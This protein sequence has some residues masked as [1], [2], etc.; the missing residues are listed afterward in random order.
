MINAALIVVY[1]RCLLSFH[2]KLKSHSAFSSIVFAPF[3][4]N[5]LKIRT[6]IVFILYPD[7]SFSTTNRSTSYMISPF[8]TCRMHE[9][10][11]AISMF[12]CH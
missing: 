12:S 10:I 11:S 3:S 1:K 2:A 6:L 7:S 4:I 8:S 5:H 9:C